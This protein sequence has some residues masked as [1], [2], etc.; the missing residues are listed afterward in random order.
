MSYTLYIRPHIDEIRGLYES[1]STFHEGDSGVD[2]FIPESFSSCKDHVLFIGHK[3]SCSMTEP[4]GN[5]CSYFLHARS[6]I[7]KSPLR[8]AN[9]VGIIDAG[10]R[11]EII[12]AFDTIPSKDGVVI[13]KGSRLVQICAPNLGPIKVVIVD[14]LDETSR[15]SGGFGSTNP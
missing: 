12:A 11:G 9:S 6:S 13:E 10:Y 7:A 3:I 4:S 8:L 5:P 15:G 2:L 14:S 1:H